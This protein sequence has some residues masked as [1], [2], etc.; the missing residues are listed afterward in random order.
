MS[1]I[2][3][4]VVWDVVKQVAVEMG[5]SRSAGVRQIAKIYVSW[6]LKHQL[7]LWTMQ[8]ERFPMDSFCRVHLIKVLSSR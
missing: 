4:V 5:I 8:D 6:L 2:D 7:H 1:F 3:C